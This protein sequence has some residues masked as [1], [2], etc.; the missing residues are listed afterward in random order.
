MYSSLDL[1]SLY[2]VLL[3][4]PK[5]LNVDFLDRLGF[6][7]SQT[8]LRRNGKVLKYAKKQ[9]NWLLFHVLSIK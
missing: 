4:S 7:S 2:V 8:G 1:N 6:V 3:L 5:Y 9:P